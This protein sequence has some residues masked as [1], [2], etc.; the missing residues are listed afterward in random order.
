M[1]FLLGFS[2]L[3]TGAGLIALLRRWRRVGEGARAREDLKSPGANTPGTPEDTRF[4]AE[5][6]ALD[7]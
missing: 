6:R 1:P 7:D 3:F 4:D 5:L 2:A